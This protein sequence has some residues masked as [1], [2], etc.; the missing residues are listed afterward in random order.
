MRNSLS[1]AW[2]ELLGADQNRTRIATALTVG[3]L[4]AGFRQIDAGQPVQ[5]VLQMSVDAGRALV[6]TLQKL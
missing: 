5:L 2:Q 4:D 6:S 1:G 3:I